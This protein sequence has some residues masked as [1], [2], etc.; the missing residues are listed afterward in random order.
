MNKRQDKNL[1]EGEVTG[2]AHRCIGDVVVYDYPDGTRL[3]EAPHG[4]S[5][6]HEEHNTHILPVGRY[7]TFKASERDH[8]AEEA[9]A[10]SD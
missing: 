7:T 5:V 8:A 10:V 1:A 2:H 6:T 4:C 3:L 9:R